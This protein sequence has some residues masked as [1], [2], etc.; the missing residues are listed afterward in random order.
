[1]GTRKIFLN[2]ILIVYAP[3]SRTDKWD[4]I[5]L[6]SFC[7]AKDI[8][9]RTTQQPANWEKIFTNP[10]SDRGKIFNIY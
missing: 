7:K 3:R 10:T 8:I 2:R 6:Q 4:A 1:M 5:Q 9:N